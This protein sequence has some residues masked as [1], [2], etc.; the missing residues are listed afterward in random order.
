MLLEEES[1]QRDVK[2]KAVGRSRS[3][4]SKVNRSKS[5]DRKINVQEEEALSPSHCLF[6]N[7]TFS[8]AEPIDSSLD[9]TLNHMRNTHGFLIPDQDSLTSLDNFL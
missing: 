5:R 9:E 7:E 3:Q 4:D 6:C 2:P 1:V 8:E